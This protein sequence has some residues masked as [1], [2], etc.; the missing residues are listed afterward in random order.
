MFVMS[1]SSP[2]PGIRLPTNISPCPIVGAVTEVR[3]QTEQSPT[4]VPGLIYSAVCER[5]PKQ[6]ELEQAQ[7]P[8]AARAN[9]PELRYAPTVVMHGEQLSLHVGPRAF[10]LSMNTPAYPGWSVYRDTL[11]W[12]LEKVRPLKLIKV[13][14]RLGLR[15]TDFFTQ[16]LAECLQ[17]DLIIGGRSELS[18]PL[19]VFSH[20]QRK[21]HVCR[22]HISNHAVLQTA[23]GAKQGCLLDVDLGFSADP[24]MYWDQAIPQFEQAHAVQKEVFFHELLK[25][26][27][28]ASLNPQY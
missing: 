26:A 7:I 4:V 28:L 14:E 19:Q 2:A 16:P 3:F 1:A 25:P 21:G 8:D 18:Q 22:V 11:R 27:F 23:E 24:Q 20:L 5:F 13:P 12:V 17:V 10:F 9:M 15:Y 6:T